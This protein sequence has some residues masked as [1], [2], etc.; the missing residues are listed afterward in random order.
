MGKTIKI[1]NPIV[2]A[3]VLLVILAIGWFVIELG[4]LFMVGITIAYGIWYY[5]SFFGKN[6]DKTKNPPAQE[7]QTQQ[8][9]PSQ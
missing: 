4:P 7:Q 5:N 1:K 9:P 8:Q 2:G 6:K 3:L